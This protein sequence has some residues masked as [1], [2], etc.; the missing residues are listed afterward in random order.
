MFSQPSVRKRYRQLFAL[1]LLIPSSAALIMSCGG[2]SGGSGTKTPTVAFISQGT[3]NSWAA[4]LDAVARKTAKANGLN[5]VYFNGEGDATKQLPLI[6]QA[7]A[8]HPDAIVLVPLGA[9]ADTGPVER[10][11]SK[12]I[13]VILCDST[14]NTENYTS[15]VNPNAET[16]TVPIAQW[17]AD[18]MNHQG[19]LLYI[20]G[21]PGNA[22]TIAYDKGFNQVMQQNPNIKIVNGGNASYSI[23]TAK[24]LAATAIA[25]GKKFTGVWGLGG[26][27]VTGIMQAYIDAKI[28]PVP[29]ISGASA[30]NGILRLAIEN[31]I[32]VASLQFPPAD[33]KVCI[34]TAAKAIK[35]ESVPKYINISALPEYGPILPPLDKY[36]KPEYSDDLYVGTE[37]V[38]T[39]DELKAINLLR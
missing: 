22:T 16:A 28:Q 19:N 5:L 36:Y 13:K 24:Q 29:P 18:K 33:S 31:K 15:L 8:Q 21:L 3:S 14:V 38:L 10:A 25:S 12:G 35:G 20:G 26:E 6:D 1:G 32:D 4:Q 30:T 37:S 39:R 11:M 23:S 7:I 17:L 9:A 2:Q 27:A 34:E